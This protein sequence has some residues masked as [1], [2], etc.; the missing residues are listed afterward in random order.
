MPRKPLQTLI[1]CALFVPVLMVALAGAPEPVPRAAPDAVGL[2]PERLR[3]ATELLG[4]YVTEQKIAGAV[5]AVAR[6]GK[7]AYL[8]AVGVQDLASRTP[9]AEGSLFRIYSMTKPVT[10]VAAMM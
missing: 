9:M 1:P 7:L 6:R 10:A 8:E 5:A 2:V 4:R 3:E